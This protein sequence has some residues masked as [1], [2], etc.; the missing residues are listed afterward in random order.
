[1]EASVVTCA[2]EGNLRNLQPFQTTDA[3]SIEALQ[4]SINIQKKAVGTTR[5][6]FLLVPDLEDSAF[7]TVVGDPDL[8]KGGKDNGLPAP[9]RR[10][11]Q[12]LAR[13]RKA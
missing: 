5:A 12:N 11:L 4:T 1:M 2:Q 10:D 7:D 3:K 6:Q 13:W 8:L 9:E